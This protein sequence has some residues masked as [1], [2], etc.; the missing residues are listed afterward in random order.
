[1]K[2]V[3]VVYSMEM[4]GAEM[5][6]A[7]LSRLQ[8]KKG[9]DVTVCAYSTLG[10][11]G[12]RLL[13]EGIHV[14]VMGEAHPAK[15]MM[16]YLRLFRMMRPDVVHCHNPAPTLQAAV[17]AR[18]SGAQCVVATRHSLVSPPYDTAAE[19]KFG[20]IALWVD[21]VVGICEITCHNLRGAPLA[22][23]DR[24]V[25]VYNGAEALT[26][27]SSELRDGS[28]FTLLFVGRVAAIKDLGTL[29][30]AV[31]IARREEPRLRLWIVGDGPVRSA[32]ETL[33]RTLNLTAA[34]TFW[35]QQIGTE[36]FF[37][38]ADAVAMSSTSE[39][40]PMSLL[41]GMS[42]GLP[43]TV[44][45]VGGMKEIVDLSRGG[46]MTPVGDAEAM[47][48]SILSLIQEP[49]LREELGRNARDT[50]DREFTLERMEAGYAKLYKSSRRS[51]S[52]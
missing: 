49:S 31:A 52:N 43:A 2:I 12:E 26:A 3:H 36:R 10:I 1:M 4:G 51:R 27:A 19:I 28:A 33:S 24:I 47:A 17:G 7:Q 11:L 18:L 50:Y 37:S 13:D 20:I 45:A 25:R 48:Q 32:L 14:H 35:G 21:W 41:Q 38:A 29:L 22:R 39:G 46:L 40:L 23:P 44:T 42:L 34:V 16:R 6:V 15:T 8:R 30:K 5:L 9:H